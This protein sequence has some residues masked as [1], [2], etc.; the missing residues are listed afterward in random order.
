MKGVSSPADTS[1]VTV[2]SLISSPFVSVDYFTLRVICRFALTFDL[3]A[4]YPETWM[5]KLPT[6][7]KSS[8]SWTMN[9]WFAESNMIC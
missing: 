8:G 2:S 3:E 9:F 4:N 7:S 5:G 6:L 1:R